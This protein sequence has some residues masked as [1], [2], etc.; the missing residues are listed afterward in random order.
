MPTDPEPRRVEVEPRFTV[1]LSSPGQWITFELV[2]PLKVPW[3]RSKPEREF[4]LR[5]W[6]V[7]YPETL[8]AAPA[9]VVL[10]EQE[11]E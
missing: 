10:T 9:L 6:A 8:C 5:H 2:L 7:L 11:S 3:P 4:N 1:P